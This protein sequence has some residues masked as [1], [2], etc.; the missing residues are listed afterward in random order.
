MAI[1]QGGD[2]P[3]H[4]AVLLLASILRVSALMWPL[5]HNLHLTP[6]AARPQIPPLFPPRVHRPPTC[7][8]HLR[9]HI[10]PTPTA[11]QKFI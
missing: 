7:I 11:L 3:C 9:F 6:L 4:S 8:L 10:P 5:A 2:R 1:S